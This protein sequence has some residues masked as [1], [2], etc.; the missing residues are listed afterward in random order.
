MQQFKFLY[1]CWLVLIGVGED[2]SL[3]GCYALSKGEQ[4][5]TYFFY[6]HVTMNRNKF[7]YNKTN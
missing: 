3:L 4:L 7:I 5:P 6:V 2:S 1:W